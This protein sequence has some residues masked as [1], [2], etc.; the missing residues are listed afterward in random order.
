VG[1]IINI[2]FRLVDYI[3]LTNNVVP[4]IFETHG[5]NCGKMNQPIYVHAHLNLTF[6][7]HIKGIVLQVLHGI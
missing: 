2:L 3:F 7:K 4:C 5:G 1:P 6:E